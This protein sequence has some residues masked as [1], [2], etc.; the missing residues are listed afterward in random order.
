VALLCVLGLPVRAQ[1]LEREMSPEL[2]RRVPE[3]TVAAE[4][5]PE[6][7]EDPTSFTSVIQLEEYRGEAKHVEDL[8]A[9]AV[10]VQVRRFGGDAER[11][12]VSIRG[13]TSAQV[14]ILLDGVRL[15]SAQSGSVDLSTIPLDLLEGIEITRGGGSAGVGSDA[16]GGVIRLVSRRPGGATRTR[17]NAGA[18]SF[19][20][21]EGSF[22]RSG[23]EEG[24]EYALGYQGFKTDGDYDFHRPTVEIGGVEIVPSPEEAE[25][26]NNRSEQ[27][28]VL[29]NLGR[30]FG[31][32]FY[33]SLLDQVFFVSRGQPGLDSGTGETAGQRLRAHERRTRNIASLRLEATELGPLLLEASTNL[34][35]RYEKTEFD[36][37]DPSLGGPFGDAI[38]TRDENQAFGWQ[39]RL[40]HRFSPGALSVRT[41]LEVDLRLDTLDSN[42]FEDRERGT[43][44]V[45]LREELG[46]FEERFRLVPA[47][48]YERTRDFDDR[49]IPRVGAVFE[50]W[51]WLRLKGSW[52]RSYRIPSL[53]ELFLPD[54]GF[55]RGNP[56]LQPEEAVNVDA[57]VE[58]A[59]D[60]WGFLRRVRVQAV[61]FR[62]RIENSIVFALINPFTVAPINTG[63]AD[64]RGYELAGEV[65]LGSWLRL[66]A[67][68]TWLDARF[69]A[70]NEPLPGRPDREV[71]FRAVIEP[72]SS[73]F[74]LVGEVHYTDRLPVSRGGNVFL[75]SRTVYDASLGVNLARRARFAPLLAFDELWLVLEARNL[76]DRGMRDA[77][78]FPQPGRQLAFRIEAGW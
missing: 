42:D 8:L 23:I 75:E 27:H 49:W 44:G 35:H 32:T 53:D 24:L 34:F 10:G 6:S 72:P 78:F 21:W 58:L 45:L 47:L 60:A 62:H 65:V 67:N 41:G 17:L 55:L 7:A 29:V 48:R 16:V 76:G 15:N 19:G 64:Q 57:G 13:S 66:V 1:P 31:D 36:D 51:S 74:K 5:L 4:R 30:A 73:P 54:K 9:E 70:S 18:A 28:A 50:P 69:D 33:A 63:R 20:T 56:R 25:R 37:P 61:W 40:A 22:A 12:E 71:S 2:R 26:V 38:D 39:T 46:W 43:L 59:F 11:S 77:R 14:V 3:I 68:G 52:E